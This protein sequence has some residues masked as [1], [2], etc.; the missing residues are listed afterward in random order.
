M[1]ANGIPGEFDI[2]LG[3]IASYD[4]RSH[5]SLLHNLT[6]ILISAECNE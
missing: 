2:E 5:D 6:V 1:T 3:V 4:K